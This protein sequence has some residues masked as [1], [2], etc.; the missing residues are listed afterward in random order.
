MLKNNIKMDGKVCI[1]CDVKQTQLADK[2]G[3]TRQYVKC[4]IKKQE[5]VGKK[6]FVQML[7]ALGYGME[8]NYVK[9]N[10]E[11]DAL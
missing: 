6:N 2:I 10:D 4:I 3:A 9:R 5:G 1:E 8:L 11:G 7:E